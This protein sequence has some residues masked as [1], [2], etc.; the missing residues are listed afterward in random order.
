[1][2]EYTRTENVFA[3]AADFHRRLGTIYQNLTKD[4]DQKRV[5]LFLDYLNRHEKRF[6][7]ALE[8]YDQDMQDKIKNTWYQYVPAEE[9]LSTEGIQLDENMDIDQVLQAALEM[10]NRLIRF[11]QR[12]A[13]NVGAPYE[14]REVF[15]AMVEQQKQ[16]KRDLLQ[17]AQDLKKL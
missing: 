12:L 10:D 9:T 4:A 11:L 15:Q 7:E 8:R 5:K 16:E 17:S 13:D 6:A 2:G 1:M 14:T 3:I